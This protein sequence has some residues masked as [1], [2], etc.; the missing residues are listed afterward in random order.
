MITHHG[1]SNEISSACFLF[2]LFLLMQRRSVFFCLE[3][4]QLVSYRQP[5]CHAMVFFPRF[6]FFLFC[7]RDH[8]DITMFHLCRRMGRGR[9][10]ANQAPLAACL[11][12]VSRSAA[13]R[14][15]QRRSLRVTS[16][17]VYYFP[18]TFATKLGRHVHGQCQP[19]CVLFPMFAAVYLSVVARIGCFS[20]SVH[21]SK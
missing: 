3:I 15:F 21:V 7:S 2:R 16:N 6:P 11:Q 5:V 17:F 10:V 20:V 12:L 1:L 14:C 13:N 4:M 9:P 18:I 19:S 8:D